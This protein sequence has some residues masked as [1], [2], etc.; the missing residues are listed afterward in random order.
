MSGENLY[1]SNTDN[2]SALDIIANMI[3]QCNDE[4]VKQI[5][6]KYNVG[7]KDEVIYKAILTALKYYS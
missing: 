2:D 4:D 1:S 7:E 3:N 5:L 6:A